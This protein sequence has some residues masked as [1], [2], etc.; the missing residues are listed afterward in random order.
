VIKNS[1]FNQNQQS[2]RRPLS[3]RKPPTPA[4]SSVE[5]GSPDHTPLATSDDAASESLI[6]L[7]RVLARNAARKWYLECQAADEPKTEQ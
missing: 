7:V 3:E 1:S 2:I 5:L 4:K 6:A